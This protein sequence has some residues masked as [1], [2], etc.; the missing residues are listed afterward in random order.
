MAICNIE[1]LFI[2][3]LEGIYANTSIFLNYQAGIHVFIDMLENIST[4]KLVLDKDFFIIMCYSNC[5][6]IFMLQLGILSNASYVSQTTYAHQ[7]TWK[8]YDS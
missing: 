5:I 8:M 6:K 1:S 2:W 4:C 7:I 3:T